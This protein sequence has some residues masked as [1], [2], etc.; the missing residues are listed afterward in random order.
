MSDKPQS[1]LWVNDG[2]WWA[3]VNDA[4][5]LAIYKLDAG[6]WAHVFTIQSAVV[7]SFQGGTS[8]VLWDGTNLFVAAFGLST[9]KI[10]KLGY[11]SLTQTYSVLAGFPKSLA[12]STGSE[13]IVLDKDSTGRVWAT[14]EAG[15]KIY[16]YY[17][18]SSDHTQ[19]IATPFQVSTQT[20]DA[21]DIASVVAFG[22]DKIGVLWTDQRE[23]QV[24][25]R[26]RRD[27]DSPT[28]WQPV[29]I[30]RSGFGCID[31]H[32][33]MKADSQGR[34]YFVAKDY[35]DAVW[36]GRRD[37]DGIWT[38]DDGCQRTRLRDTSDPADRR[39]GEQA[40]RLLHALGVVRE[41]RVHTPSKNAS[42]TSTI[43]FSA[44]QPW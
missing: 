32:I 33:N 30:A 9:S 44:C 19:W 4:T 28:T 29:E 6:A 25:F 39:V 16:A 15:G 13:T 7:P 5:N 38:D 27:T 41:L 23:Q 36:V 14:Y 24:C 43:C 31:D 42:H 22:G 11:D 21:D 3:C 37:L 2:L 26:W 20:V 17:S 12:M 18:I 35:F 1:K 8:D 10:Y 34:V 40:L